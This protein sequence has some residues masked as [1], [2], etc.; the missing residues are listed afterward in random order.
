MT[1]FLGSLDHDVWQTAVNGY[2][3]AT[4]V[5]DGKSVPKPVANWN[6]GEKNLTHWNNRAMN[7]IYNGIT[8]S[9]FCKIS[10]CTIAK[11]AQD[12]L[13]TVHEGIDIVRQNKLQNLTT[14]FQTIRMKD[15]ETFD[16][17]NAKLGHI[18]NSSFN[19]GEPIPNQNVV[20]KILQSLPKRFRSKVI[21]IEEHTNL[22]ELTIEELVGSL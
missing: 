20:K 7:A 8:H 14:A 22:N 1:A 10:T 4:V 5:V 13:R 15:E 17:F 21:G 11:A 3:S 19:L 6:Q 18:V 16:E 9:E 2:K 12:L